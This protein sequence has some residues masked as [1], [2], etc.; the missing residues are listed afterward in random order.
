MEKF[1]DEFCVNHRLA[2]A[3]QICL[4]L[5]IDDVFTWLDHT[6]PHVLDSWIGYYVY[7]SDRE[8]EAMEAAKGGSG[9]MSMEDAGK[10]MSQTYGGDSQ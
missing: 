9:S 2:W 6:A 3:F 10:Y 7:K 1:R 4:E 8:K 5:R